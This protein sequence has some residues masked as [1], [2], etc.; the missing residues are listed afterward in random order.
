MDR[1]RE[2]LVLV[3]NDLDRARVGGDGG[4]L[5]PVEPLDGAD[6]EPRRLP[7]E[8]LAIA[9]D[10]EDADVSRADQKDVAARHA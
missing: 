4:D 3:R 5:P 9:V 2:R 10:G 6:A 1:E 8:A 7:H